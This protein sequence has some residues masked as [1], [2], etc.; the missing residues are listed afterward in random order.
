ME[1]IIF[2][3]PIILFKKNIIQCFEDLSI[4]FVLL[5][6]NLWVVFLDHCPDR[7]LEL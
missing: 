3:N 4:N 6:I 1:S 7:K 2:P 5:S